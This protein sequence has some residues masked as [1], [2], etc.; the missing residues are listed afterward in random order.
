MNI[1]LVDSSYTSF[2]RFFA[3]LRW[4]SLAKKDIYKEHKDD[5]NYDWSQNKEFIE[6]YS[7]MYLESIIKLVKN[8]VY[9]D[10][11]LIFCLDC[12]QC[13]IW[14]NDHH[15]DYKGGR[16]DLSQKNNFK[17]TFKYTYETLIPNLV[18]ENENIF[19]IK[20]KEIEADDIMAL[21]VKYIKIKH[22]KLHT[23]LISGDQ[24]FYQ[25]GYDN[26]TF[27]DYKKKDP[28]KFTREEAKQQL[29]LKIINGDVSDNIVSI[30][31][32]EL[33]IS[34]K[35][36]KEIRENKEELKKYLSEYPVAYEIYKK[37]KILI[38]FKNI[39]EKY[40]KKVYKKVSKII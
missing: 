11:K 21:C 1:I 24:D 8:R 36:R 40:H 19:S 3:T 39:P 38:D 5:K 27:L 2:H 9:K 35:K 4:F 32:K 17:P 30:F 34:N 20:I 15:D 31:P 7:K 6:K 37:N 23:Y 16:V 14:R 26:L 25:L 29:L 33:K 12:P 22:K 18:K 28:I 13:E 10:S